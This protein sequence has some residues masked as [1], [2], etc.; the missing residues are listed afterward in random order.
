MKFFLHN[1]LLI[2]Q[3]FSNEKIGRNF[4]EVF[5]FRYYLRDPGTYKI[6]ENVLRKR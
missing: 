5:L 4:H 1:Y 2:V 6:G 3:L